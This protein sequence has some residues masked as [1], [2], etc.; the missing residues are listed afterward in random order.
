MSV[1]NEAAVLL[2]QTLISFLGI[3][4]VLL[5][6]R[7]LLTWFQTMEWAN[8]I[9]SFLSPVTDPF[10]NLFRSFIPPLGGLDLSPLLAFFAISILQSLLMSLA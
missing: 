8:Q 1:A 2:V 9:A 7:I 3:Y 6:V 5:I 10:L 4:Q